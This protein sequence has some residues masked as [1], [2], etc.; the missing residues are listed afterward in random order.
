M[1]K[2]DFMMQYHEFPY[3][4]K[5]YTPEDEKPFPREYEEILV[6][7]DGEFK[8]ATFFWKYAS[9]IVTE[10]GTHIRHGNGAFVIKI[11][12]GTEDEEW[13]ERNESNKDNYPFKCWWRFPSVSKIE[14]AI[15]NNK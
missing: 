15:N 5:N 6:I 11:N 14:N 13:F 7:Y 8:I 10:D 3:E 1:K 2:N 4:M 12:E 9:G